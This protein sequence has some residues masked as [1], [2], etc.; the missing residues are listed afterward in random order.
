MKITQLRVT[1]ECAFA[2]LGPGTGKVDK[3]EVYPC[4]P[5]LLLKLGIKSS[6]ILKL[7]K[8]QQQSM[9]I[10]DSLLEGLRDYQKEDVKYLALRK[11][12]GC[13][14]EQRTGK[15]PTALTVMKVKG[16]KKLL[17]TLSPLLSTINCNA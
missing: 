17:L 13:F 15:T 11:C 6:T 16:V 7:Q 12:A 2:R 9:E 4:T 10:D 14:N 1:N 8:M 5:E 3:Q